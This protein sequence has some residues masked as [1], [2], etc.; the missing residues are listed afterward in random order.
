MPGDNFI[1]HSHTT[2][3]AR[4]RA[5]RWAGTAAV[6][7]MLGACNM[8][9]QE[10]KNPNAI[11][12]ESITGSAIAANLAN[13]V[14]AS[15]TRA[16]TAILGPNAVVSDELT[17]IGSREAYRQLD[18]GAVADPRNE[19]TNENGFPFVAEARWYSDFVTETEMP[20]LLASAD[21]N[22]VKPNA[23]RALLYSA[24]IHT[25]I[26][27]SYDDFVVTQV[28]AQQIAN[29]GVAR[30]DTLFFLAIDRA[31]RGIAIA[32]SINNTG[33]V[34]D[35]TAIR[36]RARH[37]RVIKQRLVAARAA[38][39]AGTA[40]TNSN[41]L[42]N[43][44]QTT[45]DATAAI[46][47]MTGGYRFRFLPTVAVL[48]GINVGFEMNNRLETRAGGQYVNTNPQ[49]TQVLAG[50]AGIR[51]ND[52]GVATATPDNT[53]LNAINECCRQAVGQ[54]MPMTVLSEVDMQLI[55]A[56]AALAASNNAG[57][58]TAINAARARGGKPAITVAGLPA[59]VTAQQ[60]LI[61]E[62]RVGLY[63]QFRRLMD[64]YRFNSPADRWV[65]QNTAIRRNCFFPISFGEK[66]SNPNALPQPAESV[67]DA[68][69]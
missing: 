35:L 47:L 48:P 51:L 61:H 34:R 50:A 28:R 29:V 13:G 44:P 52:I 32:Q 14:G 25:M 54:T 11:T 64:H 31:T 5:L 58:E 26:G 59:G 27:E 18:E 19:Y 30:I 23:A 42:V 49:G 21:S 38:A 1:M 56:E 4:A 16:M 17:W 6:A 20:P 40:V 22:L 33:L 3:G 15:V 45:A 68:C 66:L 65:T 69:R 57:F 41:P 8:F 7:A 46:A 37:S 43:D 67:T 12:E 53:L 9:D 63:L 36:A 39:A 24:M 62:R 60:L 55:V 10:V 2:A